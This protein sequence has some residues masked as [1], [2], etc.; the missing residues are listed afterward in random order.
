[1][2]VQIQQGLLTYLDGLRAFLINA[3]AQVL[4][5]EI[6]SYKKHYVYFAPYLKPEAEAAMLPQGKSR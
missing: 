5:D 2:D 3:S 4:P 1:M 6:Q